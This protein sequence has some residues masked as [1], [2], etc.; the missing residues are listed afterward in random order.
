MLDR[1]SQDGF[2]Q[3]QTLQGCELLWEVMSEALWCEGG[4]ATESS[5]RWVLEPVP[6]GVSETARNEQPNRPVQG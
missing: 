6:S 3:Q 1:V 2:P 4:A 5:G